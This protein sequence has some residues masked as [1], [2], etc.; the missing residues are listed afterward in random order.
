MSPD[1]ALRSDV[2]RL[3]RPAGEQGRYAAGQQRL[4]ML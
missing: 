4:D 3:A 2:P 1:N